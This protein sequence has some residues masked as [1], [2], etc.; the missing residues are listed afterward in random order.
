MAHSGRVIF[1]QDKRLIRSRCNL[2]EMDA[3]RAKDHSDNPLA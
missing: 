1:E 3:D 2:K